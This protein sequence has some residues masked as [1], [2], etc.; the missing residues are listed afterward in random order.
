MTQTN[1]KNGENKEGSTVKVGVVTCQSKPSLSI[2]LCITPSIYIPLAFNNNNIPSVIPQVDS[3]KGIV[4]KPYPN[5][6]R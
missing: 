1:Q 6:G 2:H 3:G 5:V 4:C